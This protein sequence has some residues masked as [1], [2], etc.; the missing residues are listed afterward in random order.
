MRYQEILDLGADVTAVGTGGRQYAK[1]FIE[2]EQV[3]FEVLLDQDGAAADIVG[4][5]KFGLTTGLNP[6]QWQAGLRSMRSGS[7]QHKTGA[8]PTQLGAT[9]VLAPGD[10]LLLEDYE[11]F[12]G[13]HADLDAVLE[14]LRSA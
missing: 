8:R 11:D 10:R 9:F 1:A 13:D 12:A 5:K 4:T 14:S 7:K 6:G 3:P 2:D